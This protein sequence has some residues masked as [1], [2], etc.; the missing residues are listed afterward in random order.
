V[1]ARAGGFESGLVEPRRTAVGE[2]TLLAQPCQQVR[3]AR[4]F[5]AGG[6]VAPL[7]LHDPCSPCYEFAVGVSG[8]TRASCASTTRVVRSKARWTAH[9]PSGR[10]IRDRV[11]LRAAR[12]F[13][14]C[15]ARAWLGEGDPLCRGA[16]D[17]L[18]HRGDGH[19]RS[20]RGQLRILWRGDDARA[21]HA[22]HLA[23]HRRVAGARRPGVA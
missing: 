19:Q 14:R 20:D 11:E 4:L 23:A 5:R 21:E 16:S 12:R 6:I 3:E 22:G 15:P 10:R 13:A 7:P 18:R 1:A 2:S 17:R 8:G 9:D